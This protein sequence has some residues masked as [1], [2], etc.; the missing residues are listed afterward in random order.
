M[1]HVNLVPFIAA[2]V[3]L[4][5]FV[6]G[7]AFYRRHIS[8]G[9]DDMLHVSGDQSRVLKQAAVAHRLDT[10]DRWGKILT[11][12]GTVSG[13][14]LAGAYLYQYWVQSSQQLWK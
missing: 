11:V 5:C 12:L 14:L 10:I 9:E 4:A 8:A 1:M 3:A 7:L 2:W 6:V 13:V